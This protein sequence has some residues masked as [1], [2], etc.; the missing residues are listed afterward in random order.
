MN[1]DIALVTEYEI[2]VFFTFRLMD[3]KKGESENRRDMFS[4]ST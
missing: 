1:T 4:T 3:D 2:I